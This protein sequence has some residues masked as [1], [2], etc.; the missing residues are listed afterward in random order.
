VNLLQRLQKA[1]LLSQLKMFHQLLH[2]LK[3]LLMVNPRKSNLAFMAK[4]SLMKKELFE[5]MFLANLAIYIM[6]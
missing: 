6:Y 1:M 5:H 4:Q 2:L 3:L